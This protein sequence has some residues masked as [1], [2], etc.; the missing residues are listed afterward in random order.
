MPGGLTALA[1]LT[2]GVGATIFTS[3]EGL[4]QWEAIYASIIAG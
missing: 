4:S 3:M 2:L 1:S